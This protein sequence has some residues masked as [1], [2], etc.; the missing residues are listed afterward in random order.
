MTFLG[1]SRLLILWERIEK[2]MI[3]N[4]NT[5]WLELQLGLDQKFAIKVNWVL[6]RN[7][8][9]KKIRNG[10]RKTFSFAFNAWVSPETKLVPSF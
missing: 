10:N 5:K 3:E 9:K 2:S 1:N 6:L 4:G 7:K 8:K